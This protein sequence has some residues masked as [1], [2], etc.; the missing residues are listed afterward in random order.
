MRT[1]LI[2]AIGA[3][4]LACVTAGLAATPAWAA[5]AQQRG[6]AGAALQPWPIT[7]TIRTVPAL[8]GI[9]FLF[10]GVPLITNRQG[11]TSFTERHN[12]DPHELSLTQTAVNT[13]GRRYTFARWSGQRDPNQAL[14]PTVRGLP[15][16]ANYTITAAFT[17]S[18]AVTPRLVK[19][20]GAP[21]PT[22]QVSRITV[23]SS[24]GQPANLS[25]SGITW[26]PCAAPAYRY[27]QLSSNDV[28]YSVQ[29]VIVDGSNVV[30]AGVERFS[31]SDTATPALRGYFYSLTISGHDALFGGALGDYA[32]LTMPNGTVRRVGLGPRHSAVVSGL[33][34][35]TY[36]VQV[37]AGSANV[38]RLTVHLSRDQTANLT[39]ITRIDLLTVGAAL[40]IGA[41]G[42]PLLSRTRRR[43]LRAVLRRSAALVWPAR[44]RASGEEAR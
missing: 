15:M 2:R 35:G 7:L 40:A 21:L 18:C 33:P 5:P 16:R 42:A 23:L 43:R 29:S 32:L 1:G 44:A 14:R 28:Q 37:K 24:L 22:A 36:Q 38:P 13:A 41:V 19:Q 4:A 12:F 8:P 25:P 9:R 6:T 34:I 20:D 39:G 11:E 17:V 30:Y 26:L 27:S 10:D 31:P 3:A